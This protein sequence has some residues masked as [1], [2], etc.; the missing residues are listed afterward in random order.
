MEDDLGTAML[1]LEREGSMAWCVIDRPGARN[2]LTPAMYYGPLQA[3]VHG[4]RQ[5]VPRSGPVDHAPG[6]RPLPFEAEHRRPQIVRHPTSSP[7]VRA[8]GL[9]TILRLLQSSNHVLLF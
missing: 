1:R 9:A 8:R 4:R 2:A 5:G 7:V 6:D 3:V